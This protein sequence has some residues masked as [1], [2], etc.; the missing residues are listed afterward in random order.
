VSTIANIVERVRD[1]LNS[2]LNQGWMF[3]YNSGSIS[4]LRPKMSEIPMTKVFLVSS[5]V[6]RIICIPAITMKLVTKT[7]IAPI[8]GWG[9][10][11]KRADSL[12]RKAKRIK[13]HPALIAIRRLVAPV[14]ADIPTLLE[15]V[16][17]P[18]PP[19]IPENIHPIPSASKPPLILFISAFTQA[20]S[21]TF[22]VIIKSP[23]VFKLEAKEA[24]RKGT[25]KATSNDQL[26]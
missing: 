17:V 26:M 12:G 6:V 3:L 25:N 19:S 23:T 4:T 7:R 10:I 18:N 9:M 16:D 20:S 14:A 1:E 2:G 15:E 5:F 8:T 11:E 24:M 22:W 21:L 13:R